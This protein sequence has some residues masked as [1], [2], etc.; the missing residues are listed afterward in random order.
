MAPNEDDVVR[1]SATKLIA[2]SFCVV[3]GLGI[4][5]VPGAAQTDDAKST[6]QR[7][8]N[9]INAGPS[10]AGPHGTGT[11]QE[12]PVPRNE[13]ICFS[14]YT[15]ADKTLKLTAQLYPLKPE[16]DREVRLEVKDGNEWKEI[17]RQGDRVR[18]DGTISRRGLGRLENVP[19]ASP[20][21]KR[22]LRRHDSQEP[23]RQGRD[24]RRGFTGNSIHLAHGGDI[25]RTSCRERQA[26]DADLLFFSGDQVYDHRHHYAAWLKFGRDFGEIIKDRPTDHDS[27][28]PRRRPGQPL[29]RGWQEVER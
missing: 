18:L 19:I 28:R 14:L 16:E 9:A 5:A 7:R 3:T 25:S 8:Q 6:N 12:Y 4:G 13:V 15:V 21:A 29:G 1:L 22:I 27:R 11:Y 26:V 10:T 2:A 20:T 24:R 17:A 23:D